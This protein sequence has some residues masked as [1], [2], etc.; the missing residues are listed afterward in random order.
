M[1][2]AD[3][4]QHTWVIWEHS[5]SYIQYRK[6]DPTTISTNKFIF[7]LKQGAHGQVDWELGLK[8]RGSGV[9]FP[10]LAMCIGVGQTLAQSIF[11]SHLKRSK[12]CGL[13]GVYKQPRW[14]DMKLH[15]MKLHTM[16]LTL[17]WRSSIHIPSN[18]LV[19]NIKFVLQIV[20]FGE[21]K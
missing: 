1:R 19:P 16:K 20:F 10:V 4:A 8:I 11:L 3:G 18:L 6:G 21:Q 7:Y 14:L 5:T 15:T 13:Y 9:Q 12:K 2:S 17:T